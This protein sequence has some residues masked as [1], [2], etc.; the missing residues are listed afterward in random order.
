MSGLIAKMASNPARILGVPCG[1]RL[2][3]PADITIIDPRHEFSIDASLFRSRSRN[4][5]FVGAKAFGKAVA[6]IVGGRVVF[7]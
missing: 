3:M 1:L 2:G 5:P 7:E 6:T 4:S